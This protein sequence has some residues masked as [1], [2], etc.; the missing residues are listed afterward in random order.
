MF[1]RHISGLSAHGTHSAYSR[2]PAGATV[3]VCV[4]V[5]E[6]VCV[7]V[8]V[9]EWVCESVP[10][11]NKFLMNHNLQF[12]T[13]LNNN[14]ITVNKDLGLSEFLCSFFLYIYQSEFILNFSRIHLTLWGFLID[15]FGS[16]WTVFWRIYWWARSIWVDGLNFKTYF[17]PTD[18]FKTLCSAVKSSHMLHICPQ[19]NP[20]L[21]KA[22]LSTL[23][24]QSSHQN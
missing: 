11:Q 2:T 15:H 4:C 19:M 22:W 7:C 9:W 1:A 21:F 5:W 3:S 14:P 10:C 20:F 18:I 13:E 17:N 12:Q 8:C 16:K 6:S 23:H 24:F